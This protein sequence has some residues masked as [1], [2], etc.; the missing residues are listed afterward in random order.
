M[1]ESGETIEPF[2]PGRRGTVDYMRTAGRRSVVHGLVELDVTEARRRIR[3]L[4]ER[5]GTKYSFTAFLISC[6]ARAIDDH[7]CVQTYRDWRGRLVRFEDV[8]VNVLIEREIDGE[9]I[10]VPHV[11]RAANRRSLE[12]IHEEIRAAQTDPNAGRQRGLSAVGLRLPGPVRR[13]FWRLPRTFPRRWKRV[14][15]TVAVT[16]IGMFGTGGGWGISPTNYALQLTVGGIDRKPGVLDGEVVPR[17]YLSLTV[18]VD[19]DVVDGAP[20]ARFVG[21]LRELVE[22]AH[23]LEPDPEA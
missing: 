21:R 18:T 20:A 8:D 6:L 1:T 11:L 12:S 16:S 10:G 23:G 4:E 15:G 17:E 2:P 9:R 14:A 5:T 19:H 3:E 22:A 7:P 13:L